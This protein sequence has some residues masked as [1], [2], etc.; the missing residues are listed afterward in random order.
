MKDDSQDLR[1]EQVH[2]APDAAQEEPESFSLEDILDEFGGWSKREPRPE[3]KPAQ[4]DIAW[5][6][7]SADAKDTDAKDADV[8]EAP[9]PDEA[10]PEDAP[11]Q[12]ATQDT[13]RFTPIRDE[14]VPPKP[15]VWRYEG[16][17]LPE[18]AA[19]AQ[20]AE[21][22][23]EARRE[24]QLRRRREQRIAREQTRQKRAANRRLRRQERPDAVYATIEDALAAYSRRSTQRLRLLGSFLL[25]LASAVLLLL[26]NI[27]IG[28]I[29][30]SGYRVAFSLAMLA[31]MLGQMLLAYDV[32]VQGILQ[33]LR[34][35]FDHLS[36]LVLLTLLAAVDAFFALAQGRLPLCTIVSVQILL[37]QW[38]RVL[39]LQA[40]YRSARAV[41]AMQDSVAVVREEKAWH[42]KDCIF[43]STAQKDEFARQ[44]EMPDAAR[45]VMRVY[46]P[47]AAVL[48]LALA[49]LCSLRG[50]QNPLWCW[51]ALLTAAYPAGA[52]I[53]F[54]RPFALVAKRLQRGGAAVAGWHGARNLSG[55][56]G[57]VVEDA[58]LF[59]QAN[60]TL[61]GMKIYSDRGVGY[62]A[63]Y[64]TAVVETAGSGLVPLFQEILQSQ[65]G[66]RFT[67]DT[68]RRYEGGGLG[69]EIRGDVVL[70]GSLAFMRLMRVQMPPDVNVKQAVYLSVNGELA[71]VFALHYAPASKVSSALT[72][73]VRSK[74][75]TPVLATRDF[76][77]T[78]QFLRYRYK[79]PP[80]R[81]E[82][83]TVEERAW[84]SSPDAVREPKQG[85]LLSQGSFLSFVS[86]VTAARSL[87]ST[88]IGSLAISLVGGIL[89]LLMVFLLA[90]IG[91]VATASCWNLAI[92]MVLWMIPQLLLTAMAGRSL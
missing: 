69:A 52:L 33:A 40:K 65:N 5:G 68:F 32:F 34:L 1:D 6:E 79:L 25:C 57:L 31:I 9:A 10:K 47:V 71:A 38:G 55:E 26:A 3:E 91:S 37:A 45:R 76:M 48:T 36:L 11:P 49:V 92:Y 56:C 82:F 12:T 72:A 88:V 15:E 54:P 86:A 4:E 35:R 90:F 51:T 23:R 89:G 19:D 46:A 62:I 22:R 24:E 60:V 2:I 20:S 18:S 78:P 80:E 39:L 16:E 81:V 73:A 21:E 85:A 84:L 83:P 67:V 59:P 63:G 66:R 70:M 27:R 13:V 14:D 53:S 30:L 8:K 77:I 43:R 74:G 61:N 75:L 42:G 64:A 50:W 87:R 58:D 41:C 17:P 29:D 28:G 44:L 7:P